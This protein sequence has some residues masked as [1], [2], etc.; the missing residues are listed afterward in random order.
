[1]TEKNPDIITIAEAAGIMGISRDTAY[2]LKK[3]GNF[4]IAAEQL[5]RGLKCSRAAAE[6]WAAK[7]QQEPPKAEAS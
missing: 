2:R 1:M 3:A 4:P 5:G 7:L 6:R